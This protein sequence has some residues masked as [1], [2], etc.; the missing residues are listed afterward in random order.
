[1]TR[2]H[3]V[4]QEQQIHRL[5]EGDFVPAQ[6]PQPA[7][8]ADARERRLHDRRIESGRIVAFETEKHGAIG[9]MAEPRQRQRSVELCVNL[10][11]AAEQ[12]AR[13]QI[14]HEH[15]RGQHRAHRVR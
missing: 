10:G 5:V 3:L 13:S 6:Q 7:A 11:G 1:M 12:V 8:A 15:P 4:A 2:Q 14:L 9:A